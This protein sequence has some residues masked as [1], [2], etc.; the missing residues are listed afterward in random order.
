MVPGCATFS[1][2]SGYAID[3]SP[4]LRSLVTKT[5]DHIP[6]LWGGGGGG[7]GV[8]ILDLSLAVGGTNHALFIHDAYFTAS[9][10]FTVRGG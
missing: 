9:L 6:L 10:N 3:C 7:Q 4:T 5:V 2:L 1:L 8:D